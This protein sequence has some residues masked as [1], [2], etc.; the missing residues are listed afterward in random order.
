MNSYEQ[1][2][3]ATVRVPLTRREVHESS[4]ETIFLIAELSDAIRRGVYYYSMLGR[5]LFNVNE[6]L[7]ALIIDGEVAYEDE[8][9]DPVIAH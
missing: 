5:Q 7:N 2:R 6:V 9:A 3:T 4:H 1:D 8:E